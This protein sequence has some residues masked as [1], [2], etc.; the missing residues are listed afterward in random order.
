MTAGERKQPKERKREKSHKTSTKNKW[1]G[2]TERDKEISAP[3]KKLR[4][5]LWPNDLEP[6]SFRDGTGH[7]VQEKSHSKDEKRV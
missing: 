2:R 5:E 6:W 3:P 4:K 7:T 1:K